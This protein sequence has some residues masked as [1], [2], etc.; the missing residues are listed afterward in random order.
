MYHGGPA[1]L[2]GSIAIG[3]YIE[4]IGN[5]PVIN[6]HE[7]TRCLSGPVGTVVE[8]RL[9]QGGGGDSTQLHLLRQD[10]WRTDGSGDAVVGIAAALRVV[11]DG[12]SVDSVIPGGPAFLSGGI[13]PDHLIT[14]IDGAKVTGHFHAH[15]ITD[16]IRGQEGSRLTLECLSSAFTG[17]P[18]DRS[19][20]EF[21]DLVSFMRVSNA[22][23]TYPTCLRALQVRMRV[24]DVQL[25]RE[26]RESLAREVDSASSGMSSMQGAFPSPSRTRQD[27]RHIPTYVSSTPQVCCSV[28]LRNRRPCKLHCSL[29]SLT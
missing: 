1:H 4:C 3:D 14:A 25:L 24:V 2:S 16:M 12:V 19:K 5:A 9:R 26:Y 13:Q 27:G 20:L 10:I 29:S 17:P 6:E 7:A 22:D 15:E 8:V 11:R 18:L 23:S 21:V 28:D